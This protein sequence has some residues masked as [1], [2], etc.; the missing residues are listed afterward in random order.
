MA[1]EVSDA[2]SDQKRKKIPINKWA[3]MAKYCYLYQAEASFEEPIVYH[4][5]VNRLHYLDFELRIAN[6]V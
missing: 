6:R 5:V 4:R 1:F 2:I 3:P